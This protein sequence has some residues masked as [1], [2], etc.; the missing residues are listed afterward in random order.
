MILTLGSEVASQSLFVILEMFGLLKNFLKEIP[1]IMLKIEFGSEEDNIKMTMKVIVGLLLNLN[2][3]IHLV[4]I[5]NPPKHS[6]Q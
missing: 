2:S 1:M 5:Q 3:K 6:E 4:I